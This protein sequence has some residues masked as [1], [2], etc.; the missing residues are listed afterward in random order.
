MGHC[1]LDIYL[2]RNLII[3]VCSGPKDPIL[4]NLNTRMV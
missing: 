1:P 2:I 3:R 4:N